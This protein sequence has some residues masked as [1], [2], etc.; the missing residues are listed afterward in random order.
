MPAV[1]Q[2]LQE[3]VPCI[4]LEV[5]SVALGAKHLLIVWGEKNRARRGYRRV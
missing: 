1:A 4:N 3:T 5:T 2:S